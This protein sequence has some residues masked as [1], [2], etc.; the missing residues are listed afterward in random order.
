MD[1]VAQG[2]FG[3]DSTPDKEAKGEGENSSVV[4][5]GK[6][7]PPPDFIMDLPN[8]SR[9]DLYVSL[10]FNSCIFDKQLSGIP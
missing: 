1:K 6:E 8:I 4:D 2:D 9:I 3:D 10:S 7:P 5:L